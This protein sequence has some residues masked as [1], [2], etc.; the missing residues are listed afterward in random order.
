ME[1]A[2]KDRDI[3]LVKTEEQWSKLILEPNYHTKKT[4]YRKFVGN[5]NE[6]DKSENE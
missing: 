1:N 4:L 5:R 2:R 6:E 3:K